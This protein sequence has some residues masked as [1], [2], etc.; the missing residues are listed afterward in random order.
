[1]VGK[2]AGDVSRIKLVAKNSSS[3]HRIL[4]WHAIL[5]IVLDD[6]VKMVNFIKSIQLNVRLFKILCEVKE[7]V[8]TS[9]LLH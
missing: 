6:A 4:H 2:C 1:M 7:S 8:R 5:K 3:R 9:L